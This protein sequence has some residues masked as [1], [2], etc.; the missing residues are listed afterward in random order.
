MVTSIY[1]LR[2]YLGM[3][4]KVLYKTCENETYL[5]FIHEKSAIFDV[6]CKVFLVSAIIC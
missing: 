5:N 4:L 6:K 3:V 2:F 1:F